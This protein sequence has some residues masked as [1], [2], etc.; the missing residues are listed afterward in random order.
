MVEIHDTSQQIKCISTHLKR[1]SFFS[2]TPHSSL[3]LLLFDYHPLQ[4]VSRHLDRIGALPDVG[5]AVELDLGHRLGGNAAAA[6]DGDIRELNK[7]HLAGLIHT[8]RQRFNRW[9]TQNSLSFMISSA[10][11]RSFSFSLSWGTRGKS[12]VNRSSNPGEE[13]KINFTF[14]SKFYE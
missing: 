7:R 9:R 14:I 6:A 2:V 8:V 13:R 1:D 3:P 5:L 12:I 11:G 4:D 10:T